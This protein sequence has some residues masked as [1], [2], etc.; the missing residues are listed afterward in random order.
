MEAVRLAPEEVASSVLAAMDPATDPCQDF[1]RY[2]CG[3]WIDATELPSDRPRWVRSI[4]VIQERNREGL[5]DIL[6]RL[7]SEAS[8][9]G[10]ESREAGEELAEK[11]LADTEKAVAFYGSCQDE[12]AIAERGLGPLKP[13]MEA[14]D[15]VDSPS[16]VL[17]LTG[18]LH[19]HN[20]FPF[21]G[22]FVFGD[23]RSPE[24]YLLYYSQGGLGLPERDFYFREDEE[25]ETL[26]EEYREHVARVLDLVGGD[27]DPATLE[28]VAEG[29]EPSPQ[30]RQR[31]QAIYDFE[32]RLAGASRD[33]ASMRN[34]ESLYNRYDAASLRELT[35]ELDWAAYRAATG[36]PE[37]DSLSVA[38]PEFFEALD[39]ALSS[40]PLGVLQDYLRWHLVSSAAQWLHPTLAREDFDFFGR[41]LSGQQNQRE[42]WSRCVDVVNGGLGD[43]VGQLFVARYFAG[44]SKERAV[45]MIKDIEHA[46]AASFP[47]LDWMD[48]PTREIAQTKIDAVRNKIGY[49]EE[50][51]SYAGVS[52]DP[53]QYFEN[54]LATGRHEYERWMRQAGGKVD[55]DEWLMTPPTVNAY[56]NPTGNE[57]VFPAGILQ[58][59]FFHRD[60]PAAMNYG[61]IGAV[62]GHELTHGF[63]DSGRKF[64][65]SGELREWWSTEV[66]ERFDERATCVADAYDRFEVEPGVAVNG[67]LTLG[68]NIADL[69][70]VKQAHFALQ[71]ALE[72]GADAGFAVGDLTPEQ[73]F[74]VS[75]GQVWCTVATPE[76]L[77][78]QVR[79]DSHSPPRFRVNG[80][81]L[82]LP[83]FAEAFSCEA[84]DGMV[85]PEEQR[86]EVW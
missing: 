12:E 72:G 67:R 44:D 2:A 60:Y 1:Y 76:H 31:A 3:G 48:D 36:F 69:G 56:Y 6:D 24:D 15:G 64:D 77:R 14:I 43:A 39:D 37:V 17:A 34:L 13:W 75:Y 30:A 53:G 85:T 42:R 73:L 45:G 7:S 47:T 82:H 46:L 22:T 54:R 52:I 81:L 55:P 9:A 20:L 16:A 8:A 58:P 40:T 4:S 35:P 28:A 63:D 32:S 50:P 78:L 74:F 57:I 70:G 49:P 62:M 84:G 59:P 65:A 21:F 80:P 83:A 10:N 19:R 79:T 86:C 18:Q 33:A 38:T 71:E 61:A 5:R 27:G 26:R 29:F 51:Q 23:F 68:E 41:Q 25:S 66:A 11:E